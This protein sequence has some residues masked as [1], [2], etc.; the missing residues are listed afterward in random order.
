MLFVSATPGAYELSVDGKPF[1][2]RGVA[3]NPAHDW[4]D[5]HRP[6]TRREL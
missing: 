4:R 6:L 3:Y 5:G 1:Y 2:V